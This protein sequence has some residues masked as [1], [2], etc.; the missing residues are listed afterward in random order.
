MRRQISVLGGWGGAKRRT[1]KGRRGRAERRGVKAAVKVTIS[2]VNA[3]TTTGYVWAS[4]LPSFP[5]PQLLRLRLGQHK[6]ACTRTVS[7][8]VAVSW[9]GGSTCV[10]STI[11]RSR[12]CHRCGASDATLHCFI[13]P[14]T[15]GARGTRPSDGPWRA[16]WADRQRRPSRDGA[17]RPPCAWA[18][19]GSTTR[20]A[21]GC[22]QTGAR[23]AR[24]KATRKVTIASAA[25]PACGGAFLGGGGGGEG[26]E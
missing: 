2:P 10:V 21:A 22:G 9:G 20:R 1:Q 26:G 6:P 12:A 15:R 14:L 25:K 23:R 16:R 4:P 13:C 17:R 7:G 8:E 24:Q 5:T 3:T 19:A 18:R 11:R